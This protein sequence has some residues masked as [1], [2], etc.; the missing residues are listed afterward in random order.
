MTTARSAADVSS[1]ELCVHVFPS[2]LGW[3]A[4]IARGDALRQLTFGHAS[5]RA[6]RA[7][8]DVPA[9]ADDEAAPSKPI[10]ELIRRLRSF[11]GGEDVDFSDVPLDPPRASSTSVGGFRSAAR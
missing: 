10:A 9:S 6:A 4:L 11:A 3:M 7:A 5:P 2:D 1:A 8:L